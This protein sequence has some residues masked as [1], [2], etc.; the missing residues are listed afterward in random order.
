MTEK[1]DE[2]EFND[3]FSL[4]GGQT[5][6]LTCINCHWSYN[7]SSYPSLDTVIQQAIWHVKG[8]KLERKIP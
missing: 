4:S 8:C 7:L 3:Q 5:V 1:P 6:M 2:L